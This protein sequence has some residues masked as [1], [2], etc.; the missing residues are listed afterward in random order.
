MKELYKDIKKTKWMDMLKQKK[1][2]RE[3]QHKVSN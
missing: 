1:N 3:K 2:E